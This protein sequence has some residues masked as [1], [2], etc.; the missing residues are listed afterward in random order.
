M[1]YDYS[2]QQPQGIN[3]YNGAPMP[4]GSINPSVPILDYE[5]ENKVKASGNIKDMPTT[6]ITGGGSLFHPIDAP[7]ADS[8][9][10]SVPVPLV[11]TVGNDDPNSTGVVKTQRK[12]KSPT[13][14]GNN[15]LVTG[16][17][18]KPE[19]TSGTVEDMP[20]SYTYYETTG[21][22]KE[23]L[24]QI[25]SLNGELMQEFNAVRAN[26]TMKNKYGILVGLSENVGSLISNK[27]NVIKEINNSISK[28]NELDYKKLKDI[29]A[30]QATMNDDKYIADLYKAFI[31]N[32]QM[33]PTQ[34]QL[35]PMDASLYGGGVVRATIDNG[36]LVGADGPVDASY[37]SYMANLTPEQ[38]L[39]RY[40]TNPNIKQCVV[41]NEATGEKYFQYY[42]VSTM[43]PIPNLPTYDSSI[44]EDTFIDKSKMIAK[45]NN[46]HQQ[47][48]LILVNNGVTS[49]Y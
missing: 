16:D 35:S 13:T 7:G 44:M 42:D 34:M 24:G 47:F 22:L 1:I 14:T 37:H 20:T 28:S 15:D 39:M 36:G 6:K 10:M 30:A 43:T 41:F 48:D 26:R 31:N 38:N 46:L 49:Q 4:T 25:D 23:T 12:K 29:K 27:I 32:P 45:N 5:D 17:E 2:G 21:L 8:R 3:P 11:N 9:R 19:V 18:N 33:Q 40:E